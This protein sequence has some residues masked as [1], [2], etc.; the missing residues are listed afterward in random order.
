MAIIRLPT[1]SGLEP[2]WTRYRLQLR[3]GMMMTPSPP[4]SGLHT[5]SALL[6]ICVGSAEIVLFSRHTPGYTNEYLIK[7]FMARSTSSPRLIGEAWYVILKWSVRLYIG[8]AIPKIQMAQISLFPISSSPLPESKWSTMLS[9]T[10]S[11]ASLPKIALGFRTASLSTRTPQASTI[12]QPWPK[13]MTAYALDCFISMVVM[14][15][16][17]CPEA[18]A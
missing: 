16:L 1:R 12:E 8:K 3:R 4:P 5:T 9:E 6:L 14:K 11:M 15:S 18:R 10:G 13:A 17:A 2:S 7:R